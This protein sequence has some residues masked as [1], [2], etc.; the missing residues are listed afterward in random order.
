MQQ[1]VSG[2][3]Y[4]QSKDVVVFRAVLVNAKVCSRLNFLSG[5]FL[6][7]TDGLHMMWKLNPSHLF[8]TYWSYLVDMGSPCGY[9]SPCVIGLKDLGTLR[10]TTPALY[11]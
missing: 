8:H 7:C 4:R 9:G 11:H 10:S 3:L 6:V 5:V 2:K 1:K